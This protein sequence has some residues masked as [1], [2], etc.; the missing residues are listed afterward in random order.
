M[1]CH[2]ETGKCLRR[3]KCEHACD[4]RVQPAFQAGRADCMKDWAVHMAGM[5]KAFGNEPRNDPCANLGAEEEAEFRE[6]L[7]A[8]PSRE[9]TAR[10][11]WAARALLAKMRG[12][13]S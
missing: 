6:W 9:I 5:A 13:P 8:V 2:N 11:A 4:L 10:N 1:I 3:Q 7:K 12:E